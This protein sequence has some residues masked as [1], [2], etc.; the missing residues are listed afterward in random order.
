MGVKRAWT[1]VVA[2]CA[3]IGVASCLHIPPSARASFRMEQYVAARREI[4]PSVL[5]A[6]QKGH[7]IPGMDREQ[8]RVVLGVPVRT[9]TFGPESETE[10]W[11]YPGHRLHQDQMRA[12][13]AWLFRLVFVGG[14]LTV[15]EPI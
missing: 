12:D 7:V 1:A 9:A 8:V 6:M 13:K 2:S 4:L 10:V 3:L 14:T 15:I 11:I 5:D